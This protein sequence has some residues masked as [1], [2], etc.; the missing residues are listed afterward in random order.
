MIS[1][2]RLRGTLLFALLTIACGTAEVGPP[3]NQALPDEALAARTA[4]A[5]ALATRDPAIVSEKARA[6]A[7]WEGK[8]RALDLLLADALAN[9][10]MRPAE[11][12]PILAR[13]PPGDD[14]A[15]R[16]LVFGKALRSSDWDAVAELLPGAPVDNPVRD[17]LAIRARRDPSFGEPGF[18]RA[19]AACSLLDR[20]PPVGRREIDLPVP[21]NVIAALHAWGVPQ[22]ALG[23]PSQEIDPLPERGEDPVKCRGMRWLDVEELP[24]FAPH[25]MTLGASDGV[26][27]VFVEIETEKNGHWAWASNDPTRAGRIL[28]AARIYSE[29][30]GGQKG[31]AAI[32]AKYGP[33]SP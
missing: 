19:L 4:L 8:D 28:D 14:A 10:L 31:G 12:D 24:A 30:G 1:P 33:Y 13:W 11:A 21:P 18:V 25:P 17:Q 6:A 26:H 5:E 15:Y 3:A 32:L 7:Q 22:V 2:R 23:R 16:A 20:E 29:E 27:D 9:V